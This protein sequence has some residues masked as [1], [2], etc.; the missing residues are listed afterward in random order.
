MPDRSPIQTLRHTR[1]DIE[2]EYGPHWFIRMPWKGMR[3]AEFF[4]WAKGPH[5]AHGA[6][7]SSIKVMKKIDSNTDF[8]ITVKEIDDH[9]VKEGIDVDQYNQQI[10]PRDRCR[11]A[12][13][14]TYLLNYDKSPH[15]I[16][17]GDIRHWHGNH[18][19]F[20]FPQCEAKT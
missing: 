13:M 14:L 11:A 19:L 3:P 10:L 17:D 9:V 7:M 4:N 20:T 5:W 6:W 12:A 1:T 16:Q 15:V 8:Q 18:T 2:T